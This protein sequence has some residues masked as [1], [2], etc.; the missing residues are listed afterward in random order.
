MNLHDSGLSLVWSLLGF[1]LYLPVLVWALK[2]APWHKI[3]DK[4]SQHVFL[5][6]TVIVFLTW[7]SVASIGPGL[8]FHL[9]LAALVTLMFGA[10][11]ALM[12]LSIALLGISILGNAGWMAFGLNA[13]IMAVIPVLIVWRIAVWSYQALERNFFVFILLNGFLAASISVIAA[14]A[15]AALVMAQSGLYTVEVLERS[16][17]PYIPLIAIPEGFVNGVLLLAL[18]IMKPQ[19]VSCF[20]DEQYLKGK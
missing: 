13:L 20:T 16:F 6:A 2:T 17:I 8:G 1:G 7:N 4:P 5:G 3:S 19:W 14:S 15:V 9:L 18:V 11:F 10:Q 12:S